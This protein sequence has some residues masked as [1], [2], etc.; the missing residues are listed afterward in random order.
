VKVSIIIPFYNETLVLDECLQSIERQTYH[1]LELILVSDVASI[2]AC[3]VA[4]KYCD[5]QNKILFHLE[6]NSG[7][8]V[9]RNLGLSRAT[10]EYCVFLDADDVLVPDALECI[11]ENFVTHD[12]D[13]LTYNCS[14]IGEPSGSVGYKRDSIAFNNRIELR[15]YFDK[16]VLN[17]EYTPV[18]WL[19]SFRREFLVTNAITFTS[20]HYFEDN[21][22][23][24]NACQTA[25]TI[26]MIDRSLI[27][28]RKHGSSIT[29]S[30]MS[31]AKYVSL[32]ENAQ[33]FAKKLNCRK[34]VRVMASI[35]I[36]MPMDTLIS[37]NSIK[38]E[39]M[40]PNWKYACILGS[41]M[42]RLHYTFYMMLMHFLLKKVKGTVKWLS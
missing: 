6:R 37:F 14:L 34:S 36:A 17:R 35:Y 26:A 28:H 13:V 4:S 32:I 5:G 22:F 8:G 31:A 3:A 16:C 39:F 25:G 15:E 18:V 11:V 29:G 2:A 7:P 41:S 23:M 20:T 27:K 33:F 38:S 21:C 10:G 12:V 19:H 30:K 1:D 40:L 24:F 9:A 42:F